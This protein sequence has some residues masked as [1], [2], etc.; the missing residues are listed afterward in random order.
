M[1][2]QFFAFMPQVFGEP[3][4]IA[5]FHGAVGFTVSRVCKEHVQ[6]KSLLH[7]QV[8]YEFGHGFTFFGFAFGNEQRECD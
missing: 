3:N 8:H 1:F 2:S 5:D 4:P 6:H 7:N